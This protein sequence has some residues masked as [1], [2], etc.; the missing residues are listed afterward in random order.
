MET[1][2]SGGKSAF[3]LIEL[4]IVVA[5][6]GLLIGLLIPNS[7]EFRNRSLRNQ[8]TNNLACPASSSSPYER[9]NAL[10]FSPLPGCA[11]RSAAETGADWQRAA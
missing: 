2:R 9:T 6:I 10:P 1:R 7:E 5:I 3:T 8:C 4:L 11:G